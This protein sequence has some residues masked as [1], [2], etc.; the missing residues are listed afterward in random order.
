MEEPETWGPAVAALA[1]RQTDLRVVQLY[2]AREWD[3]D[4]A[5]AARFVSPEGGAALPLDPARVQPVMQ[6]V[7]TTYLDEVRSYLSQYQAVHLLTPT[8]TPLELALARIVRA[9][10]GDAPRRP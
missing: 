5:D 7:V 1:R 4:F 8:D 10:P 2:D 6:D 9:R 3:F